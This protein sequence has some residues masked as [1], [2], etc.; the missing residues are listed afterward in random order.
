MRGNVQ[1]CGQV[2]QPVQRF[3]RL[4]DP[5]KVRRAAFFPRVLVHDRV[6]GKQNSVRGADGDHADRVPRKREDLQFLRKCGML[7]PADPTAA[8]IQI[9]DAA[10][11]FRRIGTVEQGSV[12]NGVCDDRSLCG[13]RK[14][15][16]PR[17]ILKTSVAAGMVGVRMGA[18]DSRE[19]Q[20]VFSE[21]AEDLV[22]V[23]VA[24]ARVDEIGVLAA[25]IDSDIGGGGKITG[26]LSHTV[27]FVHISG[28]SLY[29]GSS[30]VSSRTGRRFIRIRWRSGARRVPGFF[31]K[32][33]LPFP[34]G[35]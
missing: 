15:R 21:N 31:G 22:G 16:T 19:G 17:H 33:G 29:C 10:K 18:D 5:V 3:Q 32:N 24:A 9:V 6:R 26:A 11:L 23:G 4:S 28:F 12:E 27:K 8:G 1:L 20:S 7:K 14:D 30:A 25:Q 35:Q 2:F 34:T 13:G